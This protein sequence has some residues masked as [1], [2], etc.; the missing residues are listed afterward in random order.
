M[1]RP[2]KT[3]GPMAAS[4]PRTKYVR[5]GRLFNGPGKSP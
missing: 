2:K 5:S 1:K 4:E 3:T